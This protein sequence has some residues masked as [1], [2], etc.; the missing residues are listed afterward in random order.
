MINCN[1]ST[2][3][4][5]GCTI[6]SEKEGI[7][8]KTTFVFSPSPRATYAQLSISA[9]KKL[10]IHVGTHV[11]SH[12]KSNPVSSSLRFDPWRRKEKIKFFSE[13]GG[14]SRCPSIPSPKW[15]APHGTPI[16]PRGIETEVF[17]S[18]CDC[19]CVSPL[20]LQYLAPSLPSAVIR[21]IF[22]TSWYLPTLGATVPS[23]VFVR[24]CTQLRNEDVFFLSLSSCMVFPVGDE[25]RANHPRRLT[26]SEVL[27]LHLDPGANLC[28]YPQ[29]YRSIH[30]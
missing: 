28:F 13:D 18:G 26:R 22:W 21:E 10:H 3:E 29:G 7:Y 20:A 8:L 19:D 15:L 27:L 23:H 30:V 4:T 9:L 16:S 1:R 11:I 14:K 12:S 2:E 5:K 24:Q 6:L 17:L 25:Y